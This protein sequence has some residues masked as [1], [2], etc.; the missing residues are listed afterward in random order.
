MKR[1]VYFLVILVTA[2]CVSCTS[3]P[4]LQNLNLG[5]EQ[6]STPDSLPDGW[7]H[8][9]WDTYYRIVA[10]STNAHSG[11]YS[12]FIEPNSGA[13]P[14]ELAGRVVYSL[15]VTFQ[16]QEIELKGYLKFEDIEQGCVGLFLRIEGEKGQILHLDNMEKAQLQG[17]SDW[18][19]Y[20]IRLPLPPEAQVVRF[21]VINAGLGRL[22]GDDLELRVDGTDISRVKPKS[23]TGKLYKADT[24]REFDAGS[25]IP[26]I[27]LSEQKTEDLH[28]LGLVWGFLKYYHPAVAAGEYNWDYE[29]FRILPKIQQ[30][31]N[32][33]QRDAVLVEWIRGM[34]KFREHKRA[35]DPAEDVKMEPDLDWISGMGLSR[36]L[37]S[38]L[39]KVKAAKR[40]PV[41]YYVGLRPSVRN[42]E[43][44]HENG[45]AGMKYPDPGY[46]M[47]SLYRYW[48]IIQYYFPYRYLIGEDWKGVLREFIPQFAEAEDE[49]SYKLACLKLIA[50]IR[51]THA[52]SPDLHGYWGRFWAPLDVNFIGQ[53]AVVKSY[54][55][56][57]KG[58]ASGLKPGDVITRVD[59][60]PVEEIVAEQLVYTPGSNYHTQLRTIGWRLLCS[61]NRQIDLEYRRGD[62]LHTATIETYNSFNYPK[63]PA[64]TCFRMATPDI[65]Y[66]HMGLIKN[67]Y[68]DQ[69]EPAVR[70]TK[71]LIIDLRTYPSDFVVFTIGFYLVP[72]STPFA[73]SYAGDLV[74]PGRFTFTKQLSVGTRNPDYYKGKVVILINEQTQ[75]SAEYHTMAFR[76]APQAV[77]MG[78]G[79]AG[80]DGN[81][82]SFLLPGG[83]ETRIT[84]IGIYYPDGT[85]TQRIGIVPDIEVKPTVEGFRDGR[86]ELLEAAIEYINR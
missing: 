7:T 43:F 60:K 57:E 4:Q 1:L 76:V 47:L 58:E 3:Q 22:W 10:D 69:L 15:P 46:R 28:V 31:A 40:P 85:E 11:N 66:L 51:D 26:K 42:P 48:N 18:K 55:D 67:D 36:E 34:G 25:A 77:V 33:A 23:N 39:L 35:E 54:L 5:F 52:L 9:K 20:S 2:G 44:K 59:G 74:M 37:E 30:A 75:S 38:E 27:E 24:D 49:V 84:G 61:R 12:I 78:S 86:D 70:N 73:K 82:S 6:I 81:V 8:W 21:G 29:L 64:D 41:H 65:G 83:I 79:T 53:Q 16:G 56:L 14:P 62:R 80:A 50:R 17:T 68:L 72:T 45:Y 71:G 32:P 63:S 13:V 19:Q